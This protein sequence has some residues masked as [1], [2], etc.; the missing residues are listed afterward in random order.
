MCK[1]EREPNRTQLRA[2]RKPE[3]PR[4]IASANIVSAFSML[5]WPTP[6][7]PP[8]ARTDPSSLR[9][10]LIAPISENREPQ[11]WH[12]EMP[13]SEHLRATEWLSPSRARSQTPE[14]FRKP[15][16]C[17][18]AKALERQRFLA[19]TSQRALARHDRSIAAAR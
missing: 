7:V 11:P 8:A 3:G 1:H 19:E 5:R 10:Y 18:P 2:N 4:A 17:T 12:Y 16:R 13:D 15:R 9:P 6:K 14:R